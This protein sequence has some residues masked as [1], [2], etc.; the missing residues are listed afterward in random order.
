MRN[1]IKETENLQA[2]KK[3]LFEKANTI[4]EVKLDMDVVTDFDIYDTKDFLLYD[5]DDIDDF[6]EKDDE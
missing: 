3:D 5:Q 1:K 4:L 2:H 6:N